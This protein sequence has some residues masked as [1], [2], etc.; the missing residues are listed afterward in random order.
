[1]L[2]SFVCLAPKNKIISKKQIHCNAIWD[3][4]LLGTLCSKYQDQPLEAPV[5][6]KAGSSRCKG[7]GRWEEPGPVGILS[8]PV[9]RDERVNSVATGTPAN[10]PRRTLPL[11]ETLAMLRF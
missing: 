9:T 1:M 11:L 6:E 5:A 8:T 10:M 4:G 2:R 3:Y 7:H